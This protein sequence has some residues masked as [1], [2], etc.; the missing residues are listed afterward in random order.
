MG[1]FFD[2]RWLWVRYTAVLDALYAVSDD[3]EFAIVQQNEPTI[4]DVKVLFERMQGALQE[5]NKQWEAKRVQTQE[6]GATPPG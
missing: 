4:A 1:R 3:L 5:A 6:K 2:Y